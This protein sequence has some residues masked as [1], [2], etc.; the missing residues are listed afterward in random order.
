MKFLLDTHVLLWSLLDDSRLGQSCS[1]IITNRE[2]LIYL[3]AA[4]L[5]EISIKEKSGKIRIEGNLEESIKQMGLQELPVNWSHAR[6]VLELPP[7]HKDPFD[8]ILIAQSRVEG[9]EFLTFDK[10]LRNYGI[11]IQ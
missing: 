5:W 7:I 4:S 10:N 3:S 8:R 6:K 9:L 1:E 2:N 11:K